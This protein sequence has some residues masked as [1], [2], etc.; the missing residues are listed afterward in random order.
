MPCIIFGV[1]SKAQE[2]TNG[3]LLVIPTTQS[4]RAWCSYTEEINFYQTIITDFVLIPLQRLCHICIN[5][6]Y[7][8]CHKQ[9]LHTIRRHTVQMRQM[10]LEVHFVAEDVL[11]EGTADDRLHWVLWQNVHLDT[12]L[13]P[14]IVVTIRT[15]IE[16]ENIE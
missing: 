2:T 4:V 8:Y 13:V 16:L 12:T 5:I 9:L 11:A 14:T 6:W 7:P 3:P 15:L 10:Q 1:Y